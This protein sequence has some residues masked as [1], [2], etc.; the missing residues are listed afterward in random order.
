MEK[1]R[2]GN[3]WPAAVSHTVYDVAPTLNR[4]EPVLHENELVKMFAFWQL[5]GSA[6]LVM[7]MRMIQYSLG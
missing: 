5:V 2:T 6:M 4:I 3:F 1:K 7:M